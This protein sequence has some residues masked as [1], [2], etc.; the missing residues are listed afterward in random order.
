MLDLHLFS[1]PSRGR[2]NKAEL[3]MGKARLLLAEVHRVGRLI[4]VEG[5]DRDHHPIVQQCQPDA[6]E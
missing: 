1:Q 4:A 2:A 5:V 3:R 6:F